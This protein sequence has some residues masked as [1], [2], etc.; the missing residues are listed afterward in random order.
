[1]VITLKKIIIITALVI[2]MNKN[3]RNALK[4]LTL[5]G[6]ATIVNQWAKPVISSVVLP[7]HA[8]TSSQRDLIVTGSCPVDL[9]E[10]Y[11]IVS[12][13][14]DPA[15]PASSIHISPKQA[16]QGQ[17]PTGDSVLIQFESSFIGLRVGVKTSN[18]TFDL[19]NI[20]FA[21]Q[22]GNGFGFTELHESP[23]PSGAVL[24]YSFTGQHAINNDPMISFENFTIV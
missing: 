13:T 6:T 21:C 19:P 17:P 3:K 15:T 1:M 18:F 23:L 20:N 4:I 8:Q 2:E 22:G 9:I 11:Y 14:P 16:G 10:F 7:A 24:K 5:G 12:F